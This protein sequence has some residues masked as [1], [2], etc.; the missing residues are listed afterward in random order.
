MSRSVIF[1]SEILVSG[2]VLYH[3]QKNLNL[4][5]RIC[6]EYVVI[7]IVIKKSPDPMERE[8]SLPYSQKAS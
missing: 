8:G 5:Y 1:V 4:N 6:L 3:R 7:V 2:S